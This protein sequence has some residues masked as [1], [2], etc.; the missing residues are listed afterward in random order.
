[1]NICCNY[2]FVSLKNIVTAEAAAAILSEKAG[3]K[4]DK[5]SDNTEVYDCSQLSE[6]IQKK[7]QRHTG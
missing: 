4:E 5:S 3:K 1:M 7:R 6:Q 2:D